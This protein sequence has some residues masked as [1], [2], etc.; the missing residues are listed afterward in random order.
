MTDTE[1]CHAALCCRPERDG[2]EGRFLDRFAVAAVAG[3]CTAVEYLFP[4][5]YAAA[6]TIRCLQANALRQVLFNA[7]P[8]DWAGGE[9]G[10][11]FEIETHGRGS[12]LDAWRLTQHS[13]G[14]R[15]AQSVGC[16]GPR[17]GRGVTNWR[18]EAG[19]R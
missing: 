12:G 14:L 3:S 16:A 11:E 8:S 5:E 6:Q 7:L 19:Q 18:R 13:V 1:D 15:P 9:R 2:H 17:C 4:Y 10:A